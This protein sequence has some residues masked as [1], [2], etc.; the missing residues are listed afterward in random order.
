MINQNLEQAGDE[1][2]ESTLDT[3]PVTIRISLV[4]DVN[5]TDGWGADVA[6]N[7]GGSVAAAFSPEVLAHLQSA[8]ICFANHEFAMSERGVALEKYYT[9]CANPA[10][11]DYWK[12][13]G[14][15]IVSLANNHAYDYGEDAFLDTLAL[16][17]SNDIKYVGGGMDLADAMSPVCFTYD[18]YTIAF[19]AADRG[20]KGDEVR[21]QAAAEGTPGVLFCFDDELFLAA[22]ANAR[23][24]GDF[25]I[26]VP[27]WGTEMSV[28][29]ELVQIELARK[30]IDT[31]ADVVVGSHPHILQGM[32]FYNDKLIVYSLGDFWFND[33]RTPTLILDIEIT[34]GKP[35]FKIT[36][37]L[38]FEQQVLSSEEI[39]AEV[40]ALMRE[41]SPETEIDDNGYVTA[42]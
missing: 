17:Q 41:L 34:D 6:H 19:V 23:E 10:Y 24:I 25:V 7:N 16:L 35:Q 5:F 4:G 8:D 3:E 15:D 20:Q 11:V 13:L 29:L 27:H 22:V 21:A 1:S 37:A 39:S 40:L 36:P 18:D 30:L 12:Q 14:V 2:L 28:E 32:E 9:F 38:Q 31:G 33:E 26:A 42:R